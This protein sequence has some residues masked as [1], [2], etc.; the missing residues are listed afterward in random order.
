MLMRSRPGGGKPR[1]YDPSK[2]HRASGGDLGAA[3]EADSAKPWGSLPTE[4]DLATRANEGVDPHFSTKQPPLV[5]AATIR[6]SPR[7]SSPRRCGAW[8]TLGGGA[9]QKTTQ[10]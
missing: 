2:P 6:I 4:D 10:D 3:S 5:A 7:S 8:G 1:P 9:P